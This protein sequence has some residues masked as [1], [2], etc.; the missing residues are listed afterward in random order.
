VKIII[1]GDNHGDTEDGGDSKINLKITFK[2]SSVQY[3]SSYCSPNT[4]LVE[5]L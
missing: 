3:L 4:Y 5:Q 1:F 2:D